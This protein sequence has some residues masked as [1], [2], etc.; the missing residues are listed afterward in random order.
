MIVKSI[1]IDRRAIPPVIIILGVMI[2]VS[3]FS[4]NMTRHKLLIVS[5]SGYTNK[6]ICMVWL[7]HFVKYNN[8]RPNKE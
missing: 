6:S 7:D 1:S 2:I 5:K 4:D 8:Y 3:W